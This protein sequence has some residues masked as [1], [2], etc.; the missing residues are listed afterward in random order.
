V[1]NADVAD[2]VDLE[3]DDEEAIKNDVMYIIKNLLIDITLDLIQ[4]IHKVVI[5][6]DIFKHQWFDDNK[7]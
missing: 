6:W 1:E 3:F 4:Q 7:R 2:E 5:T